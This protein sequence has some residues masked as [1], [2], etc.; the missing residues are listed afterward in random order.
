MISLSDHQTVASQSA[1][2]KLKV[3]FIGSAIY[4]IVTR[5]NHTNVFTT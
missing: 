3:A 2:S 4:N 1:I 5:R